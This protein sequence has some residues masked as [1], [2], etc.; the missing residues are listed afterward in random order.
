[1]ICNVSESSWSVFKETLRMVVRS[2]IQ[3][4][5]ELIEEFEESSTL[6]KPGQLV[7][8]GLAS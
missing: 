4:Q 8:E 3:H 5:V 2:Q 7:H 6:R 1:M